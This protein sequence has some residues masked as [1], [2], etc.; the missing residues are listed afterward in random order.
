MFTACVIF[1]DLMQITICQNYH[2]GVSSELLTIPSLGENFQQLNEAS[3]FWRIIHGKVE[4]VDGGLM[5]P[6]HSGHSV[7]VHCLLDDRGQLLAEW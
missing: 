6:L 5:L 3:L 4:G 1:I 7:E 2:G